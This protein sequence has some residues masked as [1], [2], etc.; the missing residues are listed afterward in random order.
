MPVSMTH[1]SRP[2]NPPDVSALAQYALTPVDEVLADPESARW[3]AVRILDGL[4]NI[5]RG[6]SSAVSVATCDMMR[7]RSRPEPADWY[8]SAW[9]IS[10]LSYR[11]DDAAF[12]M[13]T[14]AFSESYSD[15]DLASVAHSGSVV[16]PAVLLASQLQPVAGRAVLAAVT[17][18]YNIV[19]CLGSCL[20]GGNPRMSHQLK[21]FR[22]TASVGPIAACA[23]LCRL[24]GLPVDVTCR[25]LSIAC[26]QGGGLRRHPRTELSSLYVQSGEVLR[27]A[28]YSVELAAAR[29]E[30]DESMLFGDGGFMAAYSAGPLAEFRLPA[31]GATGSLATA[32][33]KLDCTPHTF[34]SALDAA[35]Q[36]AE[37][38]F[39]GQLPDHVT[40]RL[41]HQHWQAVGAGQ[42]WSPPQTIAS[43]MYD[44]PFC[45]AGA[46]VTRR[47]LYPRELG[48]ALANPA[49]ARLAPR[50]RVVGD[51]ALSALFDADPTTWPA[52]VEAER[53]DG[54]CGRVEV[55][56]PSASTWSAEMTGQ[57]VIAKA[58]SL[59][60]TRPAPD[61]AKLA[62][63]LADQGSWA[64]FWE[65]LTRLSPFDPQAGIAVSYPGVTGNPT[66]VT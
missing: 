13:G 48:Q 30:G 3:A 37:G 26:N 61:A 2:D 31:T 63:L 1:S 33:V 34:I 22:P 36:L 66:E 12:L 50:V 38:D 49:V 7:G 52:I 46:F 42:P 65:S 14:F 4:V 39:A 24:A 57:A 15:T 28:L 35:R 8:V 9:P 55:S 60:D 6:A 40:V 62:G 17:V 20:N 10:D 18:G 16:V 25:A 45:I 44:L 23:V 27:R 11:A 5:W 51:P 47:H 59:A 19:E 41:P 53:D 58:Q 32:S 56:R 29:V 54:R 64:D 21:G 43:A